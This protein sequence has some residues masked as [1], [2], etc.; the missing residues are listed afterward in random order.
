MD[1]PRR[2]GILGR[3][4]GG[5]EVN[6]AVRPTQ[7]EACSFLR[8]GGV[9]PGEREKEPASALASCVLSAL[10]FPVT[11]LWS[12]PLFLDPELLE[13][14]CPLP[15]APSS[16]AR[17]IEWFRF[18]STV[19]EKLRGCR[20]SSAGVSCELTGLLLPGSRPIGCGWR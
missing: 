12:V 4:G 14:P 16:S 9:T 13:T 18:K 8:G 2:G 11:K 5:E 10:T 6:V 20:L 15:P 3:G 7:G 17:P 19:N 1:W